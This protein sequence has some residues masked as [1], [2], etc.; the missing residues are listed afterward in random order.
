MRGGDKFAEN[1][2]SSD[3][4]WPRASTLLR[5][6]VGRRQGT[7]QHTIKGKIGR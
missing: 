4:W 5:A 6:Q 7:K 2:L 3:E 1:R